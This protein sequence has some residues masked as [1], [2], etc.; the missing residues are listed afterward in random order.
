MALKIRM[1]ILG[2]LYAFKLVKNIIANI[3]TTYNKNP[4]LLMVGCNMLRTRNSKR[5]DMSSGLL[6]QFR[7]DVDTCQSQCTE[8]HQCRSIVYGRSN[9][10]CYMFREIGNLSDDDNHDYYRKDCDGK[11]PTKGGITKISLKR[12]ME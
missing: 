9:S 10:Q 2:S 8:D 1:Q 7:A 5:G 12:K 3:T 4:C 6:K 11:R